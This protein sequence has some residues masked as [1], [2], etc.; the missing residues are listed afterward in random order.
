[1]SNDAELDAL[2]ALLHEPLPVSFRVNLHRPD[3]QR[4]VLMLA[5]SMCMCDR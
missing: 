1:M 5:F 2:M 4:Y 3:A